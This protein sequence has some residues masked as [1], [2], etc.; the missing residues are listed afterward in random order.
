MTSFLKKISI[1][2]LVL[3]LTKLSCAQDLDAGEYVN[4]FCQI[5]TKATST[6]KSIQADI[7]GNYGNFV[8]DEAQY[9]KSEYCTCLAISFSEE[10][11]QGRF[12]TFKFGGTTSW[13]KLPFAA[14]SSMVT[15]AFGVDDTAFR[16]K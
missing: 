10:N 13:S 2:F 5:Y 15:C 14:K 3:A 11:Y 16:S 4:Y 1:V 12:A 8:T 7:H 9:F 6:S